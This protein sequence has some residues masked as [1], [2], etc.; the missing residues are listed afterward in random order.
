MNPHR[1]K[2]YFYLLIVVAIWG[3]AGP[4]IKLTLGVVPWDILLL[5]RFFISSLVFIPFIHKKDFHPLKNTKILLLAFIYMIFNTTIGFALLF[6]GTARTS[7]VSMNLISLFGPILTILGGYFFLKDRIPWIEK[8]GMSIT[9]FGS[10]LLIIEPLI[11]LDGTQGE[12]TG[13]I[14]IIG[15]LIAGAISAVLLKELLR[16]GVGAIFLANIGFVVGFLTMIP[17]ALH[18]HQPSEI[19]DAISKMTLFYHLGIIYL[20]VFSGT[21]AYSLNNIAQ[22]SIEVSELAVF[23]YLYPII[24]A[25]L[26]VWFL[27]EQMTS[28]A[29]FGAGVTL[30][31][32]FITEIKRRAHHTGLAESRK[33]R[34]N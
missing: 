24:S 20:A 15:S 8:I 18:F 32:I 2:A 6:A 28:L 26:A 7:L 10:L 22:K 33:R 1:L 25:V 23:N 16:K 11:K 4:I 14:M 30:V 5:Y 21:I 31:G 19:V 27:K 3:I 29:Y 9:F 34:Y 12:I 13:N 17:I